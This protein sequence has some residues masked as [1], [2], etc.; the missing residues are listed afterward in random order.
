M[1]DNL[2][3]DK[4]TYHDQ[5]MWFSAA[6]SIGRRSSACPSMSS[7]SCATIRVAVDDADAENGCM[8]VI[9]HT[10]DHRLDRLV[11]RQ[12][13]DNASS[14]AS[15]VDETGAIDV[16]MNAGDVSVHHPNIIHGSNA[17][18]SDRRRRGLTIR[19]I[20]TSTRIVVEAAEYRE[21]LNSGGRW[22]SA[23]LLRGRAISGVNDYNAPP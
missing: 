15:T 20:P 1:I 14:M 7:K 8:R 12:D 5:A 9:P 3:R 23:F 2:D 4:R 10:H 17:N 18:R 13:I 6:R 19:Y 16:V 22:P 11:E 21:S